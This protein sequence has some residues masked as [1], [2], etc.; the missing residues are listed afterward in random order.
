MNSLA[1]VTIFSTV[2]SIKYYIP[3]SVLTFRESRSETSSSHGVTPQ[4]SVVNVK[5][6]EY[7]IL[8]QGT[9]QE[10]NIFSVNFAVLLYVVWL[11]RRAK[12]RQKRNEW[13]RAYTIS[14]QSPKMLLLHFPFVY[15]LCLYFVCRLERVSW[16]FPSVHLPSVF[17]TGQHFQVI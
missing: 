17:Q 11:H 12:V 14:E 3:N 13:R 7:F 5:Y 6:N 16:I 1:P 4:M 8:W 2:T 10:D 15:S 9:F